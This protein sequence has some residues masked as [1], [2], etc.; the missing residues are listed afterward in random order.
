MMHLVYITRYAHPIDLMIHNTISAQ[1]ELG[2][3]LEFNTAD[4]TI[5]TTYTIHYVENA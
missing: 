1:I 3:V 2:T 5:D 4:T